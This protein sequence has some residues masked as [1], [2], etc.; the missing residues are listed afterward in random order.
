METG[1]EGYV[2][3]CVSVSGEQRLAQTAVRKL[4]LR[5]QWGETLVFPLPSSCSTENTE[6]MEG[7]VALTLHICDRFSRNTT[8]GT[9]RFKLADVGMMSDADCWVNLQPP[10]QVRSIT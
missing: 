10:K 7:E 6:N 2:S 8:L 1:N 4:A 3:G 9:V 5:V